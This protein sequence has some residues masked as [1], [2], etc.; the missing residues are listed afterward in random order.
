MRTHLRCPF[1]HWYRI[2]DTSKG[3]PPFDRPKALAEL[4]SHCFTEHHDEMMELK[5]KLEDA[6]YGS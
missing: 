6:E 3:A 1:C 4:V 2:E 5:I